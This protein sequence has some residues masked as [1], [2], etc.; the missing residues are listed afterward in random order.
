MVARELLGDT[1][2]DNE[3][4]SRVASRADQ[5]DEILLYLV[6]GTETSAVNLAWYLKFMTNNP[7]VQRKLRSHLLELIPELQDR[8]MTYEDVDAG[9]VPYLEAVVQEC[10]RV[11]RVASG[12]AREGK[13]YSK[14]LTAARVDTTVLG[15]TIPKG[16]IVITPTSFHDEDEDYATWGN[17][18]AKE[19][20][21]AINEKR[22]DKNRRAGFWKGG[23][24][25][26]F[27]PERWLK[28]DGSFDANAG[29]TMP[30]SN[31]QRGCYGKNLAVSCSRCGSRAR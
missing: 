29:P 3:I 11:A 31:G 1:M 10:L 7:D 24:A 8:D 5:I 2:P 9:K 28:K 27:I 15:Y 17:G 22:H 14:T 13:S 6:A 4:V 21:D 18:N 16:T 19:A 20:A 25:R 23:S 12:F 30:F 26:S